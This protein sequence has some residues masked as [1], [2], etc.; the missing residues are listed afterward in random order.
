MSVS[1][2]MTSVESNIVA[3]DTEKEKTSAVDEEIEMQDLEKAREEEPELNTGVSANE[4]QTTAPED[5]VQLDLNKKYVVVGHFLMPGVVWSDETTGI[6][7]IGLPAADIRSVTDYIKTLLTANTPT[8]IVVL[9]YQTFIGNTEVSVIE[10]HLNEVVQAA[11]NSGIHQ[12]VIPTMYHVPIQERA[13]EKVLAINQIIRLLTLDCG[14]PPLNLHKTFLRNLARGKVQYVRPELWAEYVNRQ[15][16]GSTPSWEGLKAAKNSILKYCYAGGF[17]DLRR[18]MSKCMAPDMTPPPLCFTYEYKHNEDMMAFI[19]REGLRVPARP[20]GDQQ[21]RST[22]RQE[23]KTFKAPMPPTTKRTSSTSSAKNI[24]WKT[25]EDVMSRSPGKWSKPDLN[26]KNQE[27]F[28]SDEDLTDVEKRTKRFLEE[29]GRKRS[30][31]VSTEE[32]AAKLEKLRV[33]GKNQSKRSRIK[34]ER[35]EDKIKE[36]KKKIKKMDEN[37]SKLEEELEEKEKKIKKLQKELARADVDADEWQE[38]YERLADECDRNC[39]DG[40]RRRRY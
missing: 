31:S 39:D 23:T 2:I 28:E 16:V 1:E 34:Y 36:L 6:A 33:D 14:R 3:K 11:M 18:P 13:W 20:A 27:Q 32:L 40:K 29:K 17:E 38:A 10:K 8:N 7:W 37:E 26:K 12:I 30:P 15:G 21:V 24:G 5:N 25:K 9:V 22:A 4:G 35:F 19:K